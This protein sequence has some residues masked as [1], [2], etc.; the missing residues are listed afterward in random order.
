LRY[1]NKFVTKALSKPPVLSPVR[2][3][4]WVKSVYHYPIDS[5]HHSQGG[6]IVFKYDK[7]ARL[8]NTRN[9]SGG[10][11]PI[12]RFNESELERNSDD[13]SKYMQRNSSQ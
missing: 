12:R 11:L 10:D 13:L 8:K 1:I 5:C 9:P 6:Y 3:L 4:T 7:L 2:Y